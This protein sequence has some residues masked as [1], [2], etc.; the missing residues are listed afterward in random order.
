MKF[1]E[2][3]LIYEDKLNDMDDQIVDYINNNRE[4]FLSK[5]QK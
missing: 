1:K 2:R 4:D 5:F 3:V